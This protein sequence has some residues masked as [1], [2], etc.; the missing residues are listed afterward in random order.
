[1]N[2]AC[3]FRL[4]LFHRF[5]SLFQSLGRTIQEHGIAMRCPHSIF[6]TWLE[7]MIL[8]LLTSLHSLIKIIAAH[9]TVVFS[10]SDKSVASL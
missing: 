2:V 8:Y 6:L 1:M 4:C 9:T 3:Y 7:L 10:V 5:F